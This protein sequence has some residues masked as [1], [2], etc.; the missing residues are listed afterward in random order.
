MRGVPK[1]FKARKAPQRERVMPLA[2][3]RARSR[4]NG[5]RLN[6]YPPSPSKC[7]EHTL[8]SGLPFILGRKVTAS[9]KYNALT[10]LERRLS[11]HRVYRASGSGPIAAK[12]GS[13]ETRRFHFLDS[14][15]RNVRFCQ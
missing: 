5:N 11:G 3:T 9:R 14:F 8:P 4:N 15:K 13:M 7:G 12:G 1:W 10:P 6:K 2:G